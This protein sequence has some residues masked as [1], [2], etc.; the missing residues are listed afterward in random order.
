MA[1]GMAMDDIFDNSRRFA[2]NKVTVKDDRRG[3]DRT[4]RLILGGC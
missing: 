1:A 2:K 3:S 4:K